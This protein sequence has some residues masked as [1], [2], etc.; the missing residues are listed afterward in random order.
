MGAGLL[1]QFM[2]MAITAANHTTG[3]CPWKCTPSVAYGD[4]SPRES[5]SHDSQSPTAPYESC[6]LATP[7]GEILAALYLE[8]L[9]NS[10]AKR[11]E[12]FPLRGKWCAA[13]E[14][15]HFHGRSPVVW[16]SA[17]TTMNTSRPKCSAPIVPPATP[18]ER[19]WRSH[20]RGPVGMLFG[21]S[22]TKS[23]HHLTELAAKGGHPLSGCAGLSPIQGTEY[24]SLR[25]SMMSCST[26]SSVHSFS[27]SP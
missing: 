2:F 27:A 21:D 9:M 19:W 1:S 14:G 7:E 6:S 17:I 13:P 24:A 20:Q 10:N 18:G 12:N 25:F 15:V 4:V 11:R 5:V 23:M 22:D 3:L 8:L 16:F 26:L